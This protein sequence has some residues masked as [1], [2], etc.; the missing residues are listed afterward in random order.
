MC[1]FLANFA[2]AH[3]TSPLHIGGV[4]NSLLPLLKQSPVFKSR[5]SMGDHD[6]NILWLD[7]ER[8]VDVSRP[9]HEGISNVKVL[10]ASHAKEL[11]E[12]W[13]P[14]IVPEAVFPMIKEQLNL[15]L[16]RGVFHD[17]RLVSYAIIMRYI[18]RPS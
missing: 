10:N 3:N 18:C 16:G 15:G 17:G 7:P 8:S 14:D 4:S 9:N 11:A 6:C 2:A 5:R 13:N 1:D 12:S